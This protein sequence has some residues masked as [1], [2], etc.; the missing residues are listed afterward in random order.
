MANC[1]RDEVEL[2]LDGVYVVCSANF[3]CGHIRDYPK[4]LFGFAT[5]TIDSL[6]DGTVNNLL[7]RVF[8]ISFVNPEV[9]FG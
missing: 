4:W 2:A 9:C 8:S 5:R 1:S 3:S 6:K 7:S